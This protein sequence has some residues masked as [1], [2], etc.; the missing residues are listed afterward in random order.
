VQEARLW[1]PLLV[2]LPLAAAD[3]NAHS[4][5]ALL[6]ILAVELCDAPGALLRTD[7]SCTVTAANSG[8]QSHRIE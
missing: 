3:A 4:K 2:I 7:M 5:L 6:L 8:A 1:P